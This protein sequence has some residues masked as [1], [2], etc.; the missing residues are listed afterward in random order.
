M[1][2]LREAQPRARSYGMR[3]LM[4]LVFIAAL[5]V[6]SPLSAATISGTISD[7]T[8]AALKA[9]RVTLRAIATGQETVVDS[10]AAGRYRFDVATP[11]SYLVIVTRAGFSQAARTVVIEQPSAA[12]DV[13][14]ALELGVMNA[15]VSV[16]ASR[17][18]REV[19]QI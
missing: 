4:V 17:S 5:G 2:V 11:G 3:R 1:F 9:A 13:N 8:G 18:E 16:T 10:D 12:L 14:V 15:E 7:T 6:A 19:R